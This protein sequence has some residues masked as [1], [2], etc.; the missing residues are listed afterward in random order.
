MTYTHTK[1]Q[2]TKIYIPVKN[3]SNKTN[4]G[5]TQHDPKL[6]LALLVNL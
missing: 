5:E 6:A 3:K 1:L 4:L 2:N